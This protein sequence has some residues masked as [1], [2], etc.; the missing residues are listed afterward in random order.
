MNRSGRE[1]K[2]N[3]M[4]KRAFAGECHAVDGRTASP[5]AMAYRDE[6]SG[7]RRA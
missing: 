5:A 3:E 7:R 6:M 2:G 4:P 1:R